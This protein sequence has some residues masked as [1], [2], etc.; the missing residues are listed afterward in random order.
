MLEKQYLFLYCAWSE[1]IQVIPCRNWYNASS[2]RLCKHATIRKLT[3]QPNKSQWFKPVAV[4]LMAFHWPDTCWGGVQSMQLC[5]LCIHS[6]GLLKDVF[7]ISWEF[8]VVGA[9]RFIC[10][11]EAESLQIRQWL[12]HDCGYLCTWMWRVCTW[13]LGG[14]IS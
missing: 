1:A 13:R 2:Q 9:D 5:V 14:W 3:A 12:I 11:M 8:M 4:K 7:R 6:Q 10:A